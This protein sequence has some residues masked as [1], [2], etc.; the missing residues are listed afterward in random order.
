[1]RSFKDFLGENSVSHLSPSM[2]KMIADKK[3]DDAAK[4]KQKTMVNKELVKKG[5]DPNKTYFTR[6]GESSSTT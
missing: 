3:V 6:H 5:I 1:M 2:Q 4:G